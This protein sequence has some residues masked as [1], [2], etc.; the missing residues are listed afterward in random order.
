MHSLLEALGEHVLPHLV[1]LIESLRSLGSDPQRLVWR[2][3]SERQP[4]RNRET[5]RD[6]VE[7]GGERKAERGEREKALGILPGTCLVL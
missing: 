2:Q 4:D 6:A 5:E 3:V 1:H 7:A